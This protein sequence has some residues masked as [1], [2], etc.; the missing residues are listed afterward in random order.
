LTNGAASAPRDTSLDALKGIAI[1]VVVLSHALQWNG[2][3]GAIPLL[4]AVYLLSMPLFAYLSGF[5]EGYS[6]SRSPWELVK[7]KAATLLVPYLAWSCIGMAI[8]GL[9]L[10]ATSGPLWSRALFLVSSGPWYLAALFIF[11]LVLLIP[12]IDEGRLLSVFQVGVIVVLAFLAT[13]MGFPNEALWRNVARLLPI[14]M[15]GYLVN[16]NRD[17]RRA[18][19]SVPIAAW[20]VGYAL[21]L[22]VL[23]PAW[24][25]QVLLESFR[26]TRL[27]GALATSLVATSAL[28]GLGFLAGLSGTLLIERLFRSIGG[29][30]LGMGI[31]SRIGVYSLG[32]YVMQGYFMKLIP[33]TGAAAVTASFAVGL[34]GPFALTAVL[35]L[36]RPVRMVLF[37]GR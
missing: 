32:I 33:G 23:W 29:R 28:H 31:L 15:V 24:G 37:G 27:L 17:W 36:F 14:F 26:S 18:F 20:A 5:A 21:S 12:R 19:S 30:K 16:T 9:P 34:A 8:R 10:A 6:R 22:A 35:S 3:P 13:R 7:H 4:G 25:S 2:G 1:I 11:D